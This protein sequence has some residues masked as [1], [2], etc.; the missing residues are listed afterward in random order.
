[1]IRARH[2]SS[3]VSAVVVLAMGGGCV[4]RTVEI[5]SEPS[6]A[7]VLLNDREIG[8]TPV[9]A[10]ILYYGTYDVQIRLDGHE[11]INGA[12]E[13]KAPAWDWIGPDLVAEL[14]P[15]DFT[16][17]NAWH[18][19]LVPADV[20]PAAVLLRARGLQ[21]RTIVAEETT[22]L[23]P[24]ASLESL[25][26]EVE[27]EDALPGEDPSPATAPVPLPG[28]PAGPTLPEPLAPVP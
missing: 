27:A 13:A 24:K 7:L 20:D 3:L 17:R 2:F 23:D 22:A 14:I 5:T 12:A 4:R 21:S 18:F 15:V 10:E 1:M 26:R 28:P 16:S 6:G 8:R 9:T 25:G 19:T 11:P